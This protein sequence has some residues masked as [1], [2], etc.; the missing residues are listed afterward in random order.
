MFDMNFPNADAE[1]FDAEYWDFLDNK[2]VCGAY[3]QLTADRV[4]GASRHRGKVKNPQH[5]FYRQCE[6]SGGFD[7][8]LSRI[9]AIPVCWC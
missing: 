5:V 9:S 8:Y 1:F 3:W 7:V 2:Y 4:L 6:N